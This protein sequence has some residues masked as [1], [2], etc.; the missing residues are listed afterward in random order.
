MRR[1]QKTI[2]DGGYITAEN[3]YSHSRAV[4]LM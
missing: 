1:E 4:A 3:E 2:E